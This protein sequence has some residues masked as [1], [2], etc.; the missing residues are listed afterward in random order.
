AQALSG[1]PRIAGKMVEK[2]AQRARRQFVPAFSRA[3][4]YIGLGES[5]RALEWLEKSCEDRSTYMVFARV[6]PLLDPVSSDRRF[7]ALLRRMGLPLA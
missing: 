4:I 1:N 6:E 3:L 7:G 2:L 5:D